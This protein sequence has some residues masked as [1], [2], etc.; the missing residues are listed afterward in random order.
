MIPQHSRRAG[1]VIFAALASAAYGCSHASSTKAKDAE[2]AL[3]DLALTSDEAPDQNLIHTDASADAGDVRA[4]TGDVRADT[5]DAR[6]E[7][8]DAGV[9]TGDADSNLGV[10][11]GDAAVSDSAVASNDVGRE[12]RVSLKDT[13][14]GS[15]DQSA[16]VDGGEPFACNG[17]LSFG[18]YLTSASPGLS[19][20]LLMVDLDRDGALDLVSPGRVVC[21]TGPT[22]V[23]KLR[24]SAAGDQ[25]CYCPMLGLVA[26]IITSLQ[27]PWT[28]QPILHRLPVFAWNATSKEPPVRPVMLGLLPA[29]MP[30]CQLLLPA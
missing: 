9:D 21:M 22:P 28:S 20:P 13:S 4:D 18:D 16:G 29:F 6:A 7:T 3:P 2:A 24:Y 30:S 12:S 25:I 17:V 11:E 26:A 10:P 1:L 15:H 8:G 19:S 5:G 23:A 27:S 14:A